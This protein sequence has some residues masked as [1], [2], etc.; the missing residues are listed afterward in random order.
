MTFPNGFDREPG[1]HFSG[2]PPMPGGIERAPARPKD[3]EISFRLWIAA[4]AC[5]LVSGLLNAFV[6]SGQIQRETYAELARQGFPIQQGMT[7]MPSTS[8]AL[9]VL[10]VVIGL[11]LWGLFVLRFRDGRNWARVTLTVITA[12]LVFFQL[13][14]LVLTLTVMPGIALPLAPQILSGV[15]YL[16]AI[17]ALVFAYRPNTNAYIAYQRRTAMGR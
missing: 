12:I 16:L 8:P 9:S 6:Y 11:A 3:L 15:E 10:T 13:L 14:S 4:M 5:Y 17:A 1:Q 7:T 2:M